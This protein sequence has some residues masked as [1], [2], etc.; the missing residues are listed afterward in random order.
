MSKENESTPSED[1]LI[2][3]ALAML[4][5][6][7]EREREQQHKAEGKDEQPQSQDEQLDLAS[8]T[9][10]AL[11]SHRRPAQKTACEQCPHSVWFSS[12]TEV[13]CYCRVMYL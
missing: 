7:D 9:L 1:D 3:E 11:E 4:D 13:K 10:E 8:P 6:E 5:Q 2:E 12:P